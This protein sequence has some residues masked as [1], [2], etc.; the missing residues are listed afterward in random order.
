MVSRISALLTKGAYPLSNW[1]TALALLSIPPI[2]RHR[3]RI[4]FG[5]MVS[6]RRKLHVVAID[7]ILSGVP[8][9]EEVRLA[10]L[11]T[12]P[13][14]MSLFE[15]FC[16][17][18]ITTTFKPSVALEI[19]TYDGRS[20]MALARN[21]TGKV[22][23]VNLGPDYMDLHPDQGYR[24]DIALSRK[25]R[26]GERMLAPESKRIIQIFADSTEL[27]FNQ[28]GVMDMIVID[29]GHGYNVVKSDTENALRII[30]RERGII[31]W[32]D[33]T[34]YGVG[35]YLPALE[36]PLSIID[37]TVLAV[38]L[39]EGGQPVDIANRGIN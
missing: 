32:H 2:S 22:Y 35:Q 19:G 36:F 11:E 13:H 7:E 4:I 5:A 9:S 34:D 39:F 27:A 20:A 37:G 24:V 38:L 33:A 1:L 31:I 28:F 25:V 30:N 21:M 17:A 26:S 23:T 10:V 6:L 18:A 8:D 14:N 3:R 29:G 16:L 12:R 15:V